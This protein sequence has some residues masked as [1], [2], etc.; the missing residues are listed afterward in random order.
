MPHIDP[1]VRFWISLAVT[2]AIGVSSGSLVLTN[3]VPAEF[4]KPVT[5]WCGIIAFVGSAFVSTLNLMA[6]TDQSRIAS[7]AAVPSVATI[8]TTQAVAEASPSGK[9]VGPPTT[10]SKP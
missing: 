3:A 10:G 1:N 9:V 2:I 7:A 8:I 6:T 5:A 4:I